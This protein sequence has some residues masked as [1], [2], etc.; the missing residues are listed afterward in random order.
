MPFF[1]ISLSLPSVQPREDSTSTRKAHYRVGGW[2][3]V[4]TLQAVLRQR[5]TYYSK[6]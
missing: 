4:E 3:G 5:K 1:P 6:V 2:G